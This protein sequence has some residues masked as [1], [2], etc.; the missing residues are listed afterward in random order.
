MLEGS[1]SSSCEVP[2][3]N[4]VLLL[5]LHWQLF[6]P[7]VDFLYNWF[8]GTILNFLDNPYELCLQNSYKMV[9]SVTE[10]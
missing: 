4:F 9:F 5:Q 2:D 8:T 7:C 6:V 3:G 10:K 1:F